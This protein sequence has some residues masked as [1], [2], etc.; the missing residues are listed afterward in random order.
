MNNTAPNT[1]T[2][3]ILFKTNTTACC[4]MTNEMLSALVASVCEGILNLD[5]TLLF[6]G[7]EEAWVFSEFWFGVIFRFLRFSL[8]LL[9]M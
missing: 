7:F 6:F 4:I 5:L 2:L 1:Y 9:Q 3:Q 8:P